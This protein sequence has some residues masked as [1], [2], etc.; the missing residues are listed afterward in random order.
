MLDRVS[1]SVRKPVGKEQ[2]DSEMS[3]NR[4]AVKLT[5]FRN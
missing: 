2:K 1:V 4:Q 3:I 5:A